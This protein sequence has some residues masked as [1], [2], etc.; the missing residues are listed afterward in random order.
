MAITIPLICRVDQAVD[1]PGGGRKRAGTVAVTTLIIVT[2]SSGSMFTRFHK[3][4]C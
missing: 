3:C 4:K 1:N 2:H